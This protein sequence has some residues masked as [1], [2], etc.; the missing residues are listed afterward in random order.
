LSYKHKTNL[1]FKVRYQKERLLPSFS[2]QIQFSR[3]LGVLSIENAKMKEHHDTAFKKLTGLVK[4][5]RCKCEK[6]IDD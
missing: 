4:E 6:K 1:S 2:G 5:S 3:T